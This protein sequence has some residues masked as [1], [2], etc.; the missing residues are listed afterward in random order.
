MRYIGL[1]YIDPMSGDTGA[2]DRSALANYRSGTAI[3]DRHIRHVWEP[4][5]TQKRG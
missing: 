4:T 5:A 3:S 1:K 2:R